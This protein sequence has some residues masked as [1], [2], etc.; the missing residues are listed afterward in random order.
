MSARVSAMV[1]FAFA[2]ASMLA[3]AAPSA[4][5]AAIPGTERDALL[6]LYD[7]AGGAHWLERG[8]WRNEGD[9][10][11]GAPG[12]E[13]SWFGI[14]CDAA[15]SHVVGIAGLQGMSG[16]LPSSLS[17]LR[18]LRQLDVRDNDLIGELPDLSPLAHLAR[19][20]VDGNRMEGRAFAGPATLERGGSALCPNHFELVDDPWWDFGAGVSPWW[21][22]CVDRLFTDGFDAS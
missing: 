19:L 10:D 12:T 16:R 6:D 8:G 17:A 5:S 9:T 14:H 15:E 18:E 7:S 13:C 1:R 4:V 20:R 11:F 22:E 2:F 3:S 21:R